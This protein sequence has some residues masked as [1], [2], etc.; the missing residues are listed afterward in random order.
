MAGDLIISLWIEQ[1]IEQP[2][3]DK[4]TEDLTTI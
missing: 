4:E 2:D 1:W 3:R